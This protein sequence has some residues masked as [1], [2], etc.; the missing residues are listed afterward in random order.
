[1]PGICGA[2]FPTRF[3]APKL[4]PCLVYP[5]N[6]QR[7]QEPPRYQAPWQDTPRTHKGN[8]NPS[9][10][11]HSG[12]IPRE[13]TKAPGTPPEPSRADF[14][15]PSKKCPFYLKVYL[16]FATFS[17]RLDRGTRPSRAEPRRAEPPSR[18]EPSVCNLKEP[19]TDRLQPKRAVDRPFAT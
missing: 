11:R 8:R 13:H 14:G 6:T 7:Q 18:A 9:D 2:L 17:S 16:K 4:E 12:R 15:G 5:E 19:S 10:I 1:M 3:K